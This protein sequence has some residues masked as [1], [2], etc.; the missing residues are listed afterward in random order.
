M[1]QFKSKL[2]YK[3]Y[4]KGEFSDEKVRG[5]DETLQLIKN[6]P[7]DEQ[8]GSNIQLSGP[9]V[10]IAGDNDDYLK[11]ALY[12]NGKYCLYYLDSDGHLFERYTDDMAIIVKTV[13][14]YFEGTLSLD[15]YDKH[16]INIGNRANFENGLFEYGVN[17][18][19]TV[20][21]ILLMLFLLSI[22]LLGSYSFFLISNAPIVL[23]L[24]FFL[25]DLLCI[26]SLYLVV[27][28]YL[29]SKDMFLYL[30]QG[31]DDFQI[32]KS[33]DLEKYSKK[34]VNEINIYGQTG[35]SSRIFNLIEIAFNDNKNII[36]PGLIIDPYVFVQ[37]FPNCTKNY[38]GGYMYF[39][40]FFRQY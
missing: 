37:K 11:V 9:G 4:E 28:V 8:R 3:T 35:R 40:K 31:Q 39:T 33:G 13:T 32:W 20:A 5:L 25:L 29:K 26:Q 21:S 16:L 27:S 15:G 12:F 24:L 6:F 2:Q 36:V 23:F 38:K 10:V 7:W 17:K 22:S 30:S 19:K 1:A 34:D 14:D 18:T